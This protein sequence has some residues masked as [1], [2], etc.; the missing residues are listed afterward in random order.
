MMHDAMTS[1]LPTTSARTLQLD[2]VYNFYLPSEMR[3]TRL[4]Y[5]EME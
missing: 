4:R 2:A 5:K 1:F 3:S